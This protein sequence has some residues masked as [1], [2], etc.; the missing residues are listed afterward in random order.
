LAYGWYH[1]A[2]GIATL[3]ASLVFGWIYETYGAIWAFAWGASLAMVAAV[4]L[5]G[6]RKR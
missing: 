2:V 3:P 4:M 1:F 6:V 5:I